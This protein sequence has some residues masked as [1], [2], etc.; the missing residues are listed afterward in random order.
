VRDGE[1]CGSCGLPLI[2]EEGL[3]M[4]CR[5]KERAFDRAFPLF[6][7]SG[8]VRELLGAYKKRGRRSIALPLAKIAAREISLRWK[9]SVIVPVPPRP[10][11]IAR[12]G[13]DQ[14]EEI[15][16]ALERR[17]FPVERPLA[18]IAAAAQKRLGRELRSANARASYY[19]RSGIKLPEKVLIFDDVITTGATVDACARALKNGGARFVDVLAIAAD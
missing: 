12:K 2:S 1:R 6:P 5:G 9:D 3:C 10:G 15:V 16:R 14:V 7:Y 19:L 18:R 8:Q 11:K 13:W 17:G 4:R